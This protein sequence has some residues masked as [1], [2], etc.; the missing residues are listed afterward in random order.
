DP[1]SGRI[2]L[3]NKYIVVNGSAEGPQN[4]IINTAFDGN[5]NDG[6]NKVSTS[7]RTGYYMRKLLRMDVSVDPALTNA[8]LHYKPR[9]RFTQIYL[10][11]AEAANEAWG[12][13]GTGS[14]GFSAYDVIAAIRKR[15]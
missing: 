14:F 13:T 3:L 11:Y 12:P 9:I 4:S 5:T 6:L 7:T 1:Y 2:P 10:D 8:Q 15:E